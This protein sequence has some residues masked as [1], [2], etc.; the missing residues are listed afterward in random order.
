VDVLDY[1]KHENVA[2]LCYSPLLQGFF[3]RTD[4]TIPEE[5]NTP[6]NQEIVR[7]FRQEGEVQ[8]LSANTLVISW[9]RSQ[10]FIPLITGSTIQQMK[11]NMD[12]LSCSVSPDCDD[13]I[14]DLY[15]PHQE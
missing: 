5:Y 13:K 4:R 14:K 12:S 2:L 9:M 1:C 7:L 11:E 3:G 10:G 8:N 6:Q 15:Y